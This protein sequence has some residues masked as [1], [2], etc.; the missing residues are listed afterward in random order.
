MRASA[1]ILPVLCALLV[2]CGGSGE[3]EFAQDA[4]GV[5]VNGQPV[6]AEQI[7]LAQQTMGIP[8]GAAAIPAGRYWYDDVSGLWGFEGGPTAG[9]LY[10]GL[11]LGG[12]LQP[13]ASGGGTGVFING[14]ELHPQEVAYLQGLFGY[15]APGR[16][17]LNWQG[18]GGYEGGPAAFNLVAAAAA[19]GQAG[20]GGMYGGQTQ[21]TM[22]GGTGSDG[23]CSY[24]MH[25][26]GS[27]VMTC[28]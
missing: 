5:Y 2:G 18:V 28:N 20:Q 26:G 24:Y 21:R 9:Q 6:T 27:S 8:P 13:N 16:Y 4:E 3:R 14:R 19:A 12:P 17:W 1:T 11:Q 7:Q 23:N 22:F 25:P 15:V 10:P